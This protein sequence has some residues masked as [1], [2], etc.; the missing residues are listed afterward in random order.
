[1]MTPSHQGALGAVVSSRRNLLV[2]GGAGSGR[3]T[4]A[5]ALL[6]GVAVEER[7]VILDSGGGIDLRGDRWIQLACGLGDAAR[8]AVHAALRL[9][10]DRLVIDEV[11]GPEA[12]DILSALSGGH[13]GAIV[14]S[15]GLGASEALVRLEALA[16][17]GTGS[18]DVAAVRELL[19]R[20]FQVIA[21]TARDDNGQIV[22]AGLHEITGIRADGLDVAP[23]EIG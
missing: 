5:S 2:C 18:V 23:L 16:R 8:P 21:H 10:P 14:V 1:M 6:G 9:R 11:R 22:L 20:S 12:F 15:G 3:T 17:L 19:A 13:G 7:V 4:L